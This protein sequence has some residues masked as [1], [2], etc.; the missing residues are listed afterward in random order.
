M[1]QRVE[2]MQSPISSVSSEA[3]DF[4][5]SAFKVDLEVRDKFNQTP[6]MDAVLLKHSEI[7]EIL[8]TAIKNK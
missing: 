7:I 3:L 5:E 2:Y 8:E 1:N 4:F 6:L